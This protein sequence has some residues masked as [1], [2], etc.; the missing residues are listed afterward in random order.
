V[1]VSR[2]RTTVSSLLAAVF[3]LLFAERGE[4]RALGSAF[5]SPQA[6]RPSRPLPPAYRELLA[7][8][9]ELVPAGAPILYSSRVR[10]ETL[11]P[12][13]R[14]FVSDGR[15][16]P[17]ADEAKEFVR[18]ALA[19][20][21]IYASGPSELPFPSDRPAPTYVLVLGSVLRHPDFTPLFENAAGGLYVRK[22]P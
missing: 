18:Y 5:V 12:D 8:A 16:R 14:R 10:A 9:D 19:P 6:V 17:D 4:F 2:G 7:R 3:L 15:P 22:S 13:S 20:R 21:V 11:D 1:I